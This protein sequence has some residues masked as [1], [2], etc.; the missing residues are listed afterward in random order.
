M[1]ERVTI[2]V[3]PSIVEELRGVG[4]YHGIV[5]MSKLADAIEAALPKPEPAVGSV[6]QLLDGSVYARV[7]DAG[8][9]QPP[10]FCVPH[11]ES[12]CGDEAHCA[13][14]EPSVSVVG[15]DAIRRALEG[16]LDGATL[17]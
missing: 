12:C 5:A 9:G 11:C 1:T 15:E 7:S 4:S 16:D 2:D 10:I 13:A 3:D 8:P 6:W 14:M 17:A